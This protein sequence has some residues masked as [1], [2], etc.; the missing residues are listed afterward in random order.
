MS[1]TRTHARKYI[2]I[3]TD[4]QTHAYRAKNTHTTTYFLLLGMLSFIIPF[5]YHTEGSNFELL[6]IE[7]LILTF[8]CL[9][10]ENFQARYTRYTVLFSYSI[11]FLPHIFFNLHVVSSFLFRV[12][13]AGW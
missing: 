7:G 5:V 4:K 6:S 13:L 2:Y 12:F 9:L 1:V 3:G 8:F 11:L 10:V